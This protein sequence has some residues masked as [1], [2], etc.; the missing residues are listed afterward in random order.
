MN[1][2]LRSLDN[3]REVEENAL[4]SVVFLQDFCDLRT[5]A[6]A[7]VCNDTDPGEIVSVENGVR[8]S[9]MN[10]DHCCIEDAGLVGMLGQV[11]EHPFAEYLVEGN[12]SGANAV[13]NVR[14]GTKLLVSHHE[15]QGPF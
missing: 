10:T 7:N 2:L 15:H 14:P 3:M 5:V 9:T 11:I 13:V 6:T 4:H 12:L 8:F 1:F